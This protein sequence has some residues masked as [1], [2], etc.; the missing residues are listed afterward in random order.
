MT[1]SIVL[2]NK[3]QGIKYMTL[4][5]VQCHDLTIDN[6]DVLRVSVIY[7]LT[8]LLDGLLHLFWLEVR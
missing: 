1:S 6:R 3:V 2:V 7:D 4:V 5:I 8:A